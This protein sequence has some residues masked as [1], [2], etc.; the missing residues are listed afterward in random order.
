MSIR[1][2]VISTVSLRA[3]G[4]STFGRPAT[5]ARDLRRPRRRRRPG[6][7]ACRRHRARRGRRSRRRTPRP[8]HGHPG[9]VGEVPTTTRE[10][11]RPAGR[12]RGRARPARRRRRR[13]GDRRRRGR[14]EVPL[15]GPGVG[16]PVALGV[17]LVRRR[18]SC[19][20]TGGGGHRAGI[21]G[22]LRLRRRRLGRAQLGTVAVVLDD[23]PP[24][25]VLGAVSSPG[26]QVVGPSTP[27][28][29]RACPCP[30]RRGCRRRGHGPVTRRMNA[31]DS[32]KMVGASLSSVATW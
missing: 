11:H 19:G 18:G 22:R 8:G 27:V 26:P 10:Q 17:G 20:R 4:S 23:R 24:G 28:D 15:V 31:A 16:R 7:A 5:G 1:W 32:S 21:R 9:R 12:R 30:A 25:G 2:P 6:V 29:P 13:P 14:H 3:R